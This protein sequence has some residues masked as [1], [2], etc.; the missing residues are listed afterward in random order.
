MCTSGLM[1]LGSQS[2]G[3]VI[4][5]L[6]DRLHLHD[7]PPR[8]LLVT[9]GKLSLGQGE[10]EKRTGQQGALCGLW[11]SSILPALTGHLH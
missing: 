2:P 9:V 1:A 3:M 7:L 10:W 11:T 8:S 5:K 4:V 6:W